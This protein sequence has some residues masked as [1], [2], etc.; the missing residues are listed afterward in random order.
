MSLPLMPPPLLNSLIT[1]DIEFADFDAVV[2]PS[3]LLLVAVAYWK[4]SIYTMFCRDCWYF[5]HSM[6]PPL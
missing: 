5:L 4:L 6:L 3:K 1:A 2:G